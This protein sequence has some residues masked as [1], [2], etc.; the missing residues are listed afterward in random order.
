MSF[1]PTTL[2]EALIS[3]YCKMGLDNLWKP[4]LR[5]AIERNINDVAQG[6]QTKEQVRVSAGLLV[7]RLMCV[8]FQ[9]TFNLRLSNRCTKPCT[10]NSSVQP[11]SGYK[12]YG[13]GGGSASAQAHLTLSSLS[14]TFSFSALTAYHAT[15]LSAKELMRL[16]RQSVRLR[17][18]PPARRA[19]VQPRL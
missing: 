4:D 13:P 11:V 16:A 14:A 12:P 18:G 9:S 7:R 5:G 10:R 17:A 8:T 1:W 19:G 6:R 2:G 3:A 15:M